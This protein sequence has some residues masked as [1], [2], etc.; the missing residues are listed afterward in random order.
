MIFY[1]WKKL[2]ICNLLK[3]IVKEEDK[4]GLRRGDRK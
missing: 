2:E 3:V 4:E 1:Q